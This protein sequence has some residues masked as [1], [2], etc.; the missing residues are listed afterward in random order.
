MKVVII[1]DEIPAQEKIC[2][3]LK[4]YDKQIEVLAKIP[5]VE[6]GLE[7]F[8]KHEDFDLIISD[9]QLTDGIS[10]DIFKEVKP[11]Q[12]IIFTTAYN[13]YAIEAFKMNS[14]DYLI[15][16][17]DFEAFYKSLQKIESFR[18]NLPTPR[19]FLQLEQLSEQLV[20]MQRS[21]KKRFMVKVGEHIRSFT[22]DEIQ[23]FYAEGRDVSLIGFNKREY[24]VD[25]KLEDLEEVLDPDSFFRIGRSFIVNINAIAEIIQ[26][27]NSRLKIILKEKTEH[28]LIVSRD[29]VNNF[30]IWFSGN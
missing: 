2:E 29:R 27:S 13:E 30:K 17:F 23:V 28:E 19:R 26:H 8:K 22:T 20:Q 3:Y 5:S 11:N 12:A 15:K 4:M 18:E 14:L 10:F 1:E 6:K 9:I 7:W 21:Y 24:L 16:P 25:Y